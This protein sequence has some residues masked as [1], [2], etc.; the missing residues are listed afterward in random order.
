MPNHLLTKSDYLSG[1]Q[2]TKKLWREVNAPKSV[3]PP[4]PSLLQRFE[5]GQQVGALARKHYPNGF[6]IEP[7]ERSIMVDTTQGL[8][9][10]NTAAIFEAAVEYDGCYIR[11]DILTNN[12][13]GTWD[14]IEVKSATSLDKHPEYVDDAAFQ[15]YCAVGSGLNIR[16]VIVRHINTECR[17]PDLNNLFTD[18]DVTSLVIEK[19]PE[20]RSIISSLK[21][22]LG[23]A[24]PNILIG[25]HCEK[26]YVCPFKD[27]CWKHVPDFSIFDINGLQWKK[28]NDLIK[29][30]V[31]AVSDIPP[32]I[33][34]SEK[35]SEL[36][37]KIKTGNREIDT[38]SIANELSNLTFPLHFF[39]FETVN[40]AIPRFEG[41][42]PYSVYPFQYSCHTLHEDDTVVHREYL[43]QDRSDPRRIISERLLADLGQQGT[44]VA[45]NASYEQ[46]VI[47]LLA[48]EVND[49]E[50][51]LLNL[52]PRFWDQLLVFKQYYFDPK[53]HGSNSIKSV[54]PVIVPAL[55]YDSLE[56]VHD[57]EEAGV[58]WSRALSESDPGLKEEAFNNLRAYCEL[59]TRAMLEIHR[60]LV[61]LESA[62]L[63]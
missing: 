61:R 62:A 37:D 24:E 40:P 39:D 3:P 18:A 60:H 8:I 42:K 22:T 20:V 51:P 63:S 15:Y 53:F 2:C 6:L 41:H 12:W 47:K 59:D 46:R 30:G 48:A 43:H 26:P 55:S 28:K 23:Q 45:Y 34:L 27:D 44:I 58:V 57:G 19:Q 33:K 52:L 56:Q 32:S 4:S 25:E 50:E 49:L 14:L 11:I 54:L 9:S 17:F 16:R 38:V 10:S 31:L 35:Q 21:T 1:V 36:I 13:D 7:A 29:A 5:V